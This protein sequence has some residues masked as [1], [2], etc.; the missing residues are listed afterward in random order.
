MLVGIAW[1]PIDTEKGLAVRK[2]LSCNISYVFTLFVVTI[3]E[4]SSLGQI[5]ILLI[6]EFGCLVMGNR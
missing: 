1:E 4:M 2:D 3:Q 6:K 5:L